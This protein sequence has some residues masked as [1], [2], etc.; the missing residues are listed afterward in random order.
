MAAVEEVEKTSD[1]PAA[2]PEDEEVGIPD[3]A[4]FLPFAR[5]QDALAVLL[6]LGYKDAGAS[7][8][9][10]PDELMDELK[11]LLKDE[12]I[13]VM[14]MTTTIPN[15]SQAAYKAL[16]ITG[17]N[18]SAVCKKDKNAAFVIM[19]T[20]SNTP[21]FLMGHHWSMSQALGKEVADT[22][23]RKAPTPAAFLIFRERQFYLPSS[24]FKSNVCVASRLVA[25]ELTMKDSFFAC[26]ICN[27]T[28][29]QSK[30]TACVCVSEMGM[31]PCKHMFHRACVERHI[32]ET[33]KYSCPECNSVV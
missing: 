6:G 17:F 8:P 10:T 11:A 7:A 13:A 20:Q 21:S 23:I 9:F 33:G 2:A 27:Q 22:H 18:A 14:D 3:P 30:G 5:H 32:A 4:A 31:A 26:C 19:R 15:T 1:T 28:F 16:T 29:V 12:G 25:R 24:V